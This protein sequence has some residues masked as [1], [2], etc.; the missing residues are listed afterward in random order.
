MKV[1]KEIISK[2][3]SDIDYLLSLAIEKNI[4]IE[5]LQE[6]KNL[7]QSIINNSGMPKHATVIERNRIVEFIDNDYVVYKFN[8]KYIALPKK[9]GNAILKLYYRKLK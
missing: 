9:L 5:G 2:I 8:N 3:A 7:L 6:T 1:N 4:D